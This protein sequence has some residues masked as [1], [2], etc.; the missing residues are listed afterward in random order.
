MYCC[1]IFL[2]AGIWLVHRRLESEPHSEG[3]RCN[4]CT[5][6]FMGTHYNASLPLYLVQK[7]YVALLLHLS[8]TSLFHTRQAPAVSLV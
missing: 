2:A 3:V 4:A 7:T 8:H 5:Q 1:N 6:G